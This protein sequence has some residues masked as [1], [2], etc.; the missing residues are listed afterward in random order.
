MAGNRKA[1]EDFLIKA[2]EE[3]LPG[4]ENATIYK[5]AFSKMSDEEFESM[6]RSFQSG[7]S[8][9][10]IYSPNFSKASLNTERNIK[11]AQK[12]GHSFFEKLWIKSSHPDQP[13]YLT[14]NKFMVI[15]L[16]LRRQSQMLTKK[17]SVPANN[18]HID[19]ITGQAAGDSASAKISFP[20]LQIMRGMNL[21]YSLVELMKYRGG[22]IGGFNAMNKSIFKD[23]SVTMKA[24]EP[25]STGV[26][27][28]T[29]LKVYL[30]SAHLKNSL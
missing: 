14:N 30:T 13:A 24:L 23:G 27:S 5:E 2:I 6:M 21:D 10:V 8:R 1:A 15:E 3:M 17:I 12:Y 7:K 19:Q 29:A 26:E 4:G 18:K 28:T 9:P 22:D 25:Y 20:E 11:L 16:P